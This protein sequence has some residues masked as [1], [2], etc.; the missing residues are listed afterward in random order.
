MKPADLNRAV[1]RATGESVRLIQSLG[2]GPL[3]L[4]THHPRPPRKTR[5]VSVLLLRLGGVG[6]SQIRRA[7]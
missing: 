3:N 2:F 4:P 1:A 5:R 6:W 7:T